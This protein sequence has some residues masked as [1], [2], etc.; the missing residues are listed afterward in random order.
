MQSKALC[1]A[2]VRENRR[3]FPRQMLIMA[4]LTAF[5]LLVATFSVSARSF[6]QSVTLHVR[7]V[8]LEKVF[9]EI[10]KQ[11]GYN[12]VYNNRVLASAKP[13]TIAVNEAAVDEVLKLAV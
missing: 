7:D 4:K 2:P 3:F 10:E 6:S 1:C 9:F 8:S 12:F 13:V 5:F 11:T